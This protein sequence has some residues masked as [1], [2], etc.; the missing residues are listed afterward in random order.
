MSREEWH[1]AALNWLVRCIMTIY[2]VIAL[3]RV[4]DVAWPWA[5]AG[6][7]G[8]FAAYVAINFYLYRP[9]LFLV[10]FALT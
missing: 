2:T 1:N 9:V 10:V 3:R 7:I 5:I 6:T 8:L 4:Y